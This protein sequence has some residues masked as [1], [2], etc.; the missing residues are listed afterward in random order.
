MPFLWSVHAPRLSRKPS[1]QTLLKTNV[2]KL[3]EASLGEAPRD[4][5]VYNLH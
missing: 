4:Y 3:R 2:P 1:E 5:N